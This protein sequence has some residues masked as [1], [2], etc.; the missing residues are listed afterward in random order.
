[1]TPS[2]ASN[3]LDDD[4]KMDLMDLDFCSL[5]DGE[6]NDKL[7][8]DETGFLSSRRDRAPVWRELTNSNNLEYTLMTDYGDDGDGIETDGKPGTNTR[9]TSR[10]STSSIPSDQQGESRMSTVD[11]LHENEKLKGLT[12]QPVEIV[13]SNEPLEFTNSSYNEI[14]HTGDYS[15]GHVF[16]PETTTQLHPQGIQSSAACPPY[17]ALN[18]AQAAFNNLAAAWGASPFLFH[19]AVE[20]EQMK[21]A[22]D[23]SSHSYFNKEKSTSMI[24]SSSAELYANFLASQK[25]PQSLDDFP[26]GVPMPEFVATHEHN[27]RLPGAMACTV[28]SKGVKNAKEQKRA[29]QITNLIEQLRVKMEKDG[30]KIEVNSKFHTLSS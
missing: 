27:N 22:E 29:Q 11:H 24:S 5:L 13:S 21:N 3:D 1:M 10:S 18:M 12:Q 30:W 17:D 26:F 9:L 15:S 8:G 19:T 28:E 2:E 25:T 4:R 7:E 20:A 6:C 14:D 16:R 23:T